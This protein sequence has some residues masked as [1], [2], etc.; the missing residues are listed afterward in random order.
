MSLSDLASLGSFISGAAVLVSL[1]Y[2]AIQVR[3]NTRNVRAQNAIAHF[4]MVAHID[5]LSAEFIDAFA[6]G[7][8]ADP[9]ITSAE[10]LQFA[11]LMRTYMTQYCTDWLFD[12][13]ALLHRGTYVSS[14]ALLSR[15]VATSPGVRAWWKT[16]GWQF[17]E[18]FQAEIDRVMQ[19]TKPEL[20]TDL[21]FATWK[22]F[23]AQELG[24][25][26][27]ESSSFIS[28]QRAATPAASPGV[29]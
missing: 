5:E 16:Y 25:R 23:V 18:G 15:Y 26:G 27:D 9:A 19:E 2:L 7:V 21:G 1:I 14:Q 6:K 22:T 20:N 4:Q 28:Q 17:P 3:Q 13:E 29:P 8:R 11:F 12:S 10:Y 24:A